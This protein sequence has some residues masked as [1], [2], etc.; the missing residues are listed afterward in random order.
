MSTASSPPTAPTGHDRLADDPARG[1]P[2][3]TLELSFGGPCGRSRRALRYRLSRGG[4]AGVLSAG[5]LLVVDTKA[6]Q[7]FKSDSPSD[8]PAPP[9]TWRQRFVLFCTDAAASR[10]LHQ[11]LLAAEVGT[12]GPLPLRVGEA[13]LLGAAV[14]TGEVL[15]LGGPAAD[16]ELVRRRFLPVGGALLEAVA[17]PGAGRTRMFL[18]HRLA[19]TVIAAPI[20]AQK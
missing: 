8:D 19:G 16:L 20:N 6:L 17:R 9:L 11:R 14:V 1:Q 18:R 13:P 10:A 4:L 3:C 7:P 5:E 2:P 15:T 12:G